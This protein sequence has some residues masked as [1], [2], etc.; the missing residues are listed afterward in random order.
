MWLANEGGYHNDRCTFLP[1]K[2]GGYATKYQ[3]LLNLDGPK[4]EVM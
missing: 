1:E 2:D 3:A 4:S